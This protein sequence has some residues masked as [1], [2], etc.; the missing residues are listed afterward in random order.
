MKREIVE[1]IF[2]KLYPNNKITIIDY[3][4]FGKNMLNED[5][6]WVPDGVVVFVTV[7]IKDSDGN[8]SYFGGSMSEEVSM[9][10]GS[11]FSIVRI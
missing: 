5:N 1:K 10:T 3:E 9:Y 2:S 8:E 11:E 6:K 4:S 7:K